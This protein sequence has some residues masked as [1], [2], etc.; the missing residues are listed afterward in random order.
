MTSSSL[1]QCLPICLP[2]DR[3]L[4]SR[5]ARVIAYATSELQ[6]GE[7]ATGRA[8]VERFFWSDLCDNYLEL[9][10]ARLYQEAGSEH[11]AA[12]WTLYHALLAVLKLLAPYL[13]Y[14]TEEIYQ[15]LFRR[16]EGAAS[17]HRSSWPSERPEWLDAPAEETGKTLL[18]LLHQVRRYKAENGLSVGA[19]LASLHIHAPAEQ[20]DALQAALIDV[21]SA[22]RARSIS[23]DDLDTEGSG[24]MV[25]IETL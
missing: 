1:R 5:L 4:L 20:H 10:K 6:N 16:R 25:H 19:E 23:I 13:P 17:I 24:D 22:T 2:A 3:W 7:Y 21:K 14:I 12:Q 15:H 11:T 9:A 8:E 18:E